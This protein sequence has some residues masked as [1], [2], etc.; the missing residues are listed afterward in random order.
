MER[1]VENK[2]MQCN[3]SI[4]AKYNKDSS[5]SKKKKLKDKKEAEQGGRGRGRGRGRGGLTRGRGRGAYHRGADMK[6]II[7]EK[8]N[9]KFC[10][11][12]VTR[13][14]YNLK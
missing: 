4:T 9:L 12:V 2:F 3:D 11:I 13:C 5:K 1:Y 6:V 14:V 10:L 7:E 8:M